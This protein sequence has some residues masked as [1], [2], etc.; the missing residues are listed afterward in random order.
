MIHVACAAEG[1]YVAH[2]AAMLHSARFQGGDVHVHYLHGPAFREQ[3]AFRAFLGAHIDFYEV[4]PERVADLPADPRF[5]DAMWHRIL[6]PELLGDLDRV[7]YLDVDTI[8]L[9]DLR[10]LWETGRSPR[11]QTCSRTTTATAR[12]RSG[13]GDRAI[14]STAACCS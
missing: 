14:T 1:A 5:T 13:F 2:S 3:D 10:P 6:L 8:V 4:A 9:D 11:S 12:P 7:L